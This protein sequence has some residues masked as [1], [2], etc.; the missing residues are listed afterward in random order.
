MTCD[1]Y[2]QG[3]YYFG[4]THQT[5]DYWEKADELRGCPPGKG[6]TKKNNE[7]GVH[8]NGYPKELE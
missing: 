5:C 4:T 6:C 2:C 1:A 3:C 7:K 8:E